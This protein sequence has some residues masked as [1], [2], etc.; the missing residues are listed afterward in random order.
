MPNFIFKTTNWIHSILI[1]IIRKLRRLVVAS[2]DILLVSNGFVVFKNNIFNIS[3]YSRKLTKI[4]RTMQLLL[5]SLANICIQ[6][7]RNHNSH[8]KSHMLL[9]PNSCIFMVPI[10]SK[11]IATRRSHE[12]L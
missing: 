1:T 4:N 8:V 3:D 9:F 6:N 5:L 7:K 2:M 12:E 10:K 11:M